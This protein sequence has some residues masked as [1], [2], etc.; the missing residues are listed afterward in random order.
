MLI[1]GKDKHSYIKIHVDKE[2]EIGVR[3]SVE[4]HS[5]GISASLGGIYI[6]TTDITKF[7]AELSTLENK[8]SGVACLQSAF[9]EEF[10]LSIR[11]VNRRGHFLVTLR[12]QDLSYYEE[13]VTPCSVEVSFGIDPTSLPELLKHCEQLERDAM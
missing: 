3:F 13:L 4:T 1:K 5:R 11:C 12:M 6:V 10:S 9:P 7:L 2:D 8:R